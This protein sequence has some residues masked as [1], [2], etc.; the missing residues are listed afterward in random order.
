MNVLEQKKEPRS[1]G[2]E[3]VSGSRVAVVGGGPA[4]SFFA[5]FAL[6]AAQRLGIDLDVEIYEPRDFSCPG[7]QGCNMCGGIISESLVQFLAAEGINLP[8]GVVQRGIASYMLHTDVGSVRIDTPL[9]EQ[10]IGAVHRGPGPRDLK[11]AVWESFDGHLQRLAVDKGARVKNDRVDAID[12]ASGRPELQGR[13]GGSETYDLLAIAAGVNSQTLKLFE[14]AGLEYRPPDTTKTHIREYK[15][16]R[17]LIDKHLGDSMHVFLLNIPRL[18]FAALIPKGDYVTVCLLGD[19]I[20]N[21]L[22]DAFLGSPEVKQCF[23]PDWQAAQVSCKCSPRISVKG[24][25]QPYADRLVFI[26]DSGV[27]RLY[28]DG[29][30]A[31]YR[32]AK[33]AAMTAVMHGIA[34][35]DFAAHYQP[36]CEKIRRDNGIGKQIFAMTRQVQ[37]RRFARETIVRMTAAEQNK[38][39]ESRRMSMVLWDMF[40]GSAPYREI[41]QHAVHPGFAMGLVKALTKT[42]VRAGGTQDE[43]SG[44]ASMRRGALG[45]VYAD[46]EV[47]IRQ[48]EIGDCMHV[49]QEGQVEILRD[50]DG[51]HLR[52]ATLGAG[53]FFGEMALFERIERSATVRAVGSARILTIDKTTLL[54]RIQEDPGLAF[55][56]LESLCHRIRT[57]RT[58]APAELPLSEM[59]PTGESLPGEPA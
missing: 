11:E 29:I 13:A 34:K 22:I 31:A 7:P 28:K 26:G 3:L 18:E 35:A 43:E 54:R 19:E 55:R 48:G 14:G 44:G 58:T 16:S 36:V 15:I 32:T 52:M 23:P 42:V 1:S 50:I 40:T 47:I 24:A 33:A 53:E 39:P 9:H 41:L 27:T 8:P 17:E 5:Y 49:I 10:R 37:K 21:V 20:D 59:P 2:L 38:R 30:G 56:M 45:H 12:W 51:K 57:E 6:E 4:G 25:V 46:G